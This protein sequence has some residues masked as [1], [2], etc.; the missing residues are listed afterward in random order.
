MRSAPRRMVPYRTV[1]AICVVILASALPTRGAYNAVVEWQD[2]VEQVVRQYNISNQISA[3]FYALT[4]IAQY[5]V[6]RLSTDWEQCIP[7]SPCSCRN[8]L[9]ILCWSPG[10]SKWCHDWDLQALLANKAQ[11]NKVNDTAVT[12]MH[13]H[14]A[15]VLNATVANMRLFD[16]M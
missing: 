14:T 7:E 15:Q 11:G 8:I 9:K 10:S 3:K 16:V 13:S 12:G 5:Q 4:N 1:T 6:G 2:A